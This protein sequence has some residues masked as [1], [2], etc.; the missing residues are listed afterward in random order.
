MI[1]RATKV[2]LVLAVA[3]FYT[4]VVFNNLTDYETNYQFVRHVLMM[5]STVPGNHGVW[6]ALNGSGWHTVFYV[7]II[8]W[9]CVVMLL[10]WA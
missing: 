4:F 1:L 2:L 10:C 8:I 7:S 9:E 6:R 5:D 3:L